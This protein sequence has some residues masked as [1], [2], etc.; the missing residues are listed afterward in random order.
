MGHIA[1]QLVNMQHMATKTTAKTAL[2]R[3]SSLPV[4]LSSS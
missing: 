3:V 1:G 4:F 2:F